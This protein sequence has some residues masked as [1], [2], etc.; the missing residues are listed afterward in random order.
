[1]LGFGVLPLFSVLG[2][3]D[4]ALHGLGSF[5]TATV[6]DGLLL[7][8]IAYVLMRCAGP[9]R[10]RRRL[11]VTGAL[12]A[13]LGGLTQ[14]WWLIAPAP[15][16]NW[17]LPAPGAFNAVGWYHAAFLVGSCGFLA[18]ATAAALERARGAAG[19]QRGAVAV[20]GA[21]VP[22]LSFAGLLAVDN[23][24][25]PIPVIPPVVVAAVAVLAWVT[26]RPGWSVLICATATLPALSFSLLFL[27]GQTVDAVTVST[28]RVCRVGRCVRREH[29]GVGRQ[30]KSASRAAGHR[31]GRRGDVPRLSDRPR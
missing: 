15:R 16:L 28:G 5:R 18:A 19:T 24:R 13:I 4:S 7:P 12:G 6:G 17:S 14:V 3:G 30:C 25:S 29:G 10:H 9:M 20:L 8:L 22:A 21:L 11:A 26:R 23:D 1:M 27:P 2:F 31:T